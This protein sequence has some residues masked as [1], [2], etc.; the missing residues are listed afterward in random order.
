M[1][2]GYPRVAY[3]AAPK[4]RC[5]PASVAVVV[6]SASEPG[7]L[8]GGTQVDVDEGLATDFGKWISMDFGGGAAFNEVF[9]G[10]VLKCWPMTQCCKDAVK[11]Q[12]LGG[13]RRHFALQI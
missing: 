9:C 12:G 3:G 6:V 4:D 1:A 2:A 8:L 13:R 11:V 10:Q 7:V 5:P